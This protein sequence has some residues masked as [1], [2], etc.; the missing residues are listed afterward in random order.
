MR[1]P[2]NSLRMMG[3]ML[4]FA[5]LIMGGGTVWMWTKSTSD[6]RAHG[7]G[8]YDAGVTLYYAMQNGTAPQKA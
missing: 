5:A 6:W 8:A 3:S 7:T 4:V 2:L 1:N